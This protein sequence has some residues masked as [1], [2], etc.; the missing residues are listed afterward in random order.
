MAETSGVDPRVLS[1]PSGGGSLRGLGASFST[2]LNTGAGG[3][4]IPLELPAGP[5]GIKPKVD[6]TYQAG[7]GSGP[8]GMGWTLGTMAITRLVDAGVPTYGAADRFMLVGVGEL[9]PMPDGGWRPEVD[10]LGWRIRR[11][12]D[13]WEITDRDGVRY[14][15]GLTVDGQVRLPGNRVASWLLES[16]TDTAGNTIAYA[17]RGAAPGADRLLAEVAWGTYQLRFGYEP[18]PD[19]LCTGRYGE[20]I[21]TLD[22]CTGAELHVPGLV[23]SLVRSWEFGYE[24]APGTG[25]SLLASVVLRGHAADGSATAAPVLTLGYTEP[26]RPALIKLD[27]PALPGAGPGSLSTGQGELVDLTGD[28]LPDVLEIGPREAR[29]W[30]NLGAGRWQLPERLPQL[31]PALFSTGAAFADLNGDGTADLLVADRPTGGYYPL[32]PGGGFGTPV[33]WRDTPATLFTGGRTRLVDLD[34]DGV[35]DLLG[36]RAGGFELWFRDGDGWSSRPVLAPSAPPVDLADPRTRLAD[37]TG[38]GLTD[39]VR[40]RGGRVTYWPYLGHGRWADGR[41]LGELPG[42]PDR[43][44]P[45]RLHLIDVDGDGAADCVYVDAG[46]VLVWHNRSARGWSEPTVVRGT[47]ACRPADVRIVDLLGTGVPGVLYQ[48]VPSGRAGTA[49]LFLDLS[50]GRKPYLLASIDAGLG[51]ETGIAYRPSTGYATDDRAAGRPWRSF[52]PFPVQCVAEVVETDQITGVV[53]RLRHRYHEGHY[54]GA[55]RTFAG[56]ARVDVEEI[57]DETMPT[58]V[59]RNEYAI[60]LDPV[61]PTRVLTGDEKLRYGA[62][63]KRMLRTARYS[64]DGSAAADR[65]Y[66]QVSYEHDVVLTPSADGR[67]VAEPRQTRVLEEQWERGTSPY[68]YRE[69]SYLAYDEYGNALRQ[70]ERAWRAGGPDDLD[71]T[72]TMTFASNATTHVIGKPARVTET[73]ADGTVI[74]DLLH[75]Y[76]G[77]AH[78]GLPAG[79]VDAGFLT[80]LDRLAMPDALADSVYAAEQPD[81]AALGYRRL[82][83][84]SG[85]WVPSMSY[86]RTVGPDGILEVECRGPNGHPT[87]SR[88]DES[89]Q[90]VVRITDPAGNVRSAVP[91]PRTA[92]IQSITEAD[93][94]VF[95]DEFDALGRVLATVKPG[96]SAALPT[97]GYSYA[98]A[99]PGTPTAL[100]TRR[101]AVSGAPFTLDDVLYLDGRGQTL[102]G[103]GAG[104][105][106]PGR[107]WIARDR[108]DYAARGAVA[109]RYLPAYRSTVDYQPAPAG[110]PALEMRYDA[111]GRLLGQTRPGGA[112]IEQ[113]F[114][115]GYVIARDEGTLAGL[116][117]HVVTTRLDAERRIV[118]VEHQTSGGTAISSYAYAGRDRLVSVEEPGGGVTTMVHDL[119]GRL[120]ST[121]APDTGRVVFVLDPAGNQVE[122]RLA[123]GARSRTVLDVLDRLVAT[124]VDGSATPALR[125]EYLDAG[126]AAPAD[127]EKGRRSRLYRVTDQAGTVTFGYDALGRMAQTVRTVAALPGH[128]LV[129]DISYDALGRETGKVLPAPAP[130]GPRR[131]VSYDYDARGMLVS[132]PGVVRSAA[133]DVLGRLRRIEYG[134]GVVTTADFDATTGQP[135]AQTVTGPG[136]EVLRRNDYTFDPTGLLS[137]VD[138]L[139]EVERAGYGYDD[140]GH[141]T[142]AAYSGSSQ[143]WTVSPGGNVTSVAGIGALTYPA[144]SARV[145]AAGGEAYGYDP[146]GFLTGAPYGQLTFNGLDDLVRAELTDGRVVEQVFDYRGQ[147]AVR[148]VSGG[149]VTITADPHIEFSDGAATVWVMFGDQRVLADSPGGSAFLH[150]DGTGTGALYTDPVGGLVARVVLDPYGGLRAVLGPGGAGSIGIVPGGVRYHDQPFDADLGLLFL[151]RRAFDPRLARFIS[152]DRTVAGVYGIDSWNPYCYGRGN[153]LRNAD[154]TGQFSIGDFFAILAVVVVVAVLVVAGF[155]TFGTTWAIAGVT[156]SASAVFFGAAA[157]AAAG[158]ILGGIAAAKAGEDIWKGV[159]FG[160]L[161]GG[162][163]GAIGG[164]L[165][166]IAFNA[167]GGFAATGL[168]SY[169][170]FIVSG[171]IEGAFSG[172]GTGA[173]IGFAGGKGTAESFWTHVAKGALIGLVTGALL[174]AGSAYIKA[175]GFGLNIGLAK[176]D[177]RTPAAGGLS[178]QVDFLDS[179][180]NLGVN[181]VASPLHGATTLVGLGP[182]SSVAFHIPLG[183]VPQFVNSVGVTAT[184]D[185]LIGLDKYDVLRF[186]DVLFL[187]L[188]AAPY[189][190]G[191][192]LTVLDYAKLLDWAK[193]PTR[194]FFAMPA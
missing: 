93:G 58:L 169:L 182:P 60:G 26:A 192:T 15:L 174:G 67:W 164:A 103:Y 62:L 74:S 51:I 32:R 146:A 50:G 123:N 69:I 142:S 133:Y 154:P 70:R 80:R 9:V 137:T 46:R 41:D 159:L 57:G 194:D 101:R 18:R 144:G 112:W 31:P 1:L 82:A 116:R 190:I 109:R 158:A 121:D 168:K 19:P 29:F 188:E 180:A 14:L 165:G 178:E 176:I 187:V 124:Y 39:L 7:G 37:M 24:Q 99:G 134:N 189:F 4:G 88:Y 8:F 64:P 12:G 110:S 152:P 132:S 23:R 150:P 89:Q 179:S 20:L 95:S 68:A 138:A 10:T 106:G 163:S 25:H 11:H 84:E 126:D 131:V 151:G 111:V 72:T 65:P 28:G 91:D 54:D 156:I 16:G 166:S 97:A 48:L 115:P 47:P 2:D 161:V 130:G 125:W 44:D 42:A 22:R 128:D 167:L 34:G 79:S 175:N 75:R 172:A 21:E 61:D 127:G 56:F 76:D 135:T 92:Q 86:A 119:C 90:F 183:W 100:T 147:R 104:E 53:R 36:Q 94:S 181:S 96:D 73:T 160:G 105:G 108:V 33:I 78:V 129:T 3:Y 170:A 145:T 114:G 153:P 177:P 98:A 66:Q 5:N 141:L 193:N 148:S 173:A 77:P 38:D 27:T 157:G 71:V 143:G 107:E 52:C 43:I 149:S 81:W 6:L 63:R 102:A 186:G 59:T 13:G 17:Y 40:V 139:H 85:W 55:S 113:E 45:D 191:V 118:A 49:A 35:T 140:L 155:F 117:M 136:G 171:A 162:V 83:G 184:T 120:L 122:R 30:R 87:V 185:V